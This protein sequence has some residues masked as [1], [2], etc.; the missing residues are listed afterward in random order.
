MA[1]NQYIF[2]KSN[3]GKLEYISLVNDLNYAVLV[4]E[5]IVGK[6]YR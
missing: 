6:L 5:S 2:D 4:P 3:K 1:I